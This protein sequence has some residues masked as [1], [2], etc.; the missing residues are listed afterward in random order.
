M[1][2]PNG[3]IRHN[4][5]GSL[6]NNIAATSVGNSIAFNFL[7]NRWDDIEEAYDFKYSQRLKKF[8]T[9]FFL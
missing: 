6:F 9:V 3:G 2:D 4:D 5:V 1:L 8:S 7:I